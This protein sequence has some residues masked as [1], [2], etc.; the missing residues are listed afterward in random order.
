MKQSYFFKSFIALTII[1][2]LLSSCK[3]GTKRPAPR[4]KNIICVVDFSDSK[5][6][7]ERLQ[8]YM[9]V[10]KDN[11]IYKLGMNDKITV[12]P[13]DKASITNS[14]DILL[15]DLS[16]EVFVP[17]MASPMEEEQLTKENLKKYKESLAITFIQRFESA[18]KSRSPL[19]HGTDIFGALEIVKNKLISSD[20]NYLILL[21]DMMNWSKL[22]NMES[23]NIGFNSNK[24]DESLVLVPNFEMPHTTVLILTAE[25]VEATPEH[26]QLVKSFWT[27]Y[28]EKNHIKL[29][30]YNSASVSKLNEMMALPVTQ[31]K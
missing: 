11:I 24:L 4:R 18:I 28:F 19:N 7:N 9:K 14:T 13:I 27:K 20:D 8:F 16:S 6:A 25:Q 31:Y 15:E 3:W 30:D 26:F 17:E 2:S 21:S 22:L 10:I 29:Y 23:N 1:I 5:N 12:I